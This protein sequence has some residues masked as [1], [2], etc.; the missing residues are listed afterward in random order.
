MTG[1]PARTDGEILIAG[2]YWQWL[3]LRREVLRTRQRHVVGVA[4]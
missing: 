2:R 4:E 3:R 1:F